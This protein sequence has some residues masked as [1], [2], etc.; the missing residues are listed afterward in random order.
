[1]DVGVNV[2]VG[3]GVSVGKRRTAFGAGWVLDGSGGGA[4]VGRKSGRNVFISSP[5]SAR[6]MQT[7]MG[8]MTRRSNFALF[9]S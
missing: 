6:R 2:A 7:A 1:M 9:V 8:K 5:R 3:L 4:A